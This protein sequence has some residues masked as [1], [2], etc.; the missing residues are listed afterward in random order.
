MCGIVGIINKNGAPAQETLL[1]EMTSAITHRGPTDAGIYI[2]GS[3]GL[4]NRR[5]AIIDL[6]GGKQP[7]SNENNDL[8]I[9]YNGE[10]YNF[11]ELQNELINQGHTFRSN[12]DTEVIIHAFETWGKNC[13]NH[14]RGMFAFAIADL[15]NR[16]LFIARDQMGIKPLFYISTP[17]FFA[18]AS[19]LQALRCIPGIPL[20]ID[21]EA[22]DQ[23]LFLQ[24]I[25]AP[26]TIFQKI[27]KLK[28]AHKLTVSFDG[29][30]SEP[31]EYWQLDFVPDFTKNEN[32]WIEGLE[33]V[34]KNSI[35]AHL[36]SD[37]PFGAFLSGGID[38][39]CVV[40]YMSQILNKPVKTFTIGFE[41]EEFNEIKY[42]EEVSLYC[43]TEQYTEILKPKAL[44]ILPMLVR[45]YGEP[46]GDS[47]AIPTYYVSELAHRHVPMVLSGDGGDELFAGYG[48][49][50]GWVSL[51]TGQNRPFWRKVGRKF[52]E[53]LNPSRYP[54]KSVDLKTWFHIIKY[55]NFSSRKKLWRPEYRQQCN[56]SILEFEIYFRRTEGFEL[57]SKAQYMDLKTYLPYDILTK[58]DVAS[59]MHGLEART[60]LTDIRVAEFA[61]TIPQG[62]NLVENG[63]GQLQG[64]TILKKVLR[65]YYSEEFLNRPKMGFGVPIQSWFS[66]AGGQNHFV[67]DILLAKNS[68]ILSFFEPTE[69]KKLIDKNQIGPTW[70]LVFLDEWLNQFG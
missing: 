59:M 16:E 67:S 70:L 58:V 26:K 43:K 51:L 13:V 14:F 63:F 55:L 4:G 8:W 61:A 39:S 60:P 68:K 6:Q 17:S 2:S 69:V 3:L 27:R 11:K 53:I 47:S 42:A 9:T 15:I 30:F 41:E 1:E 66:L 64:K 52:G 12:S 56:P 29:E 34:I 36:V 5:L 32:D 7:L 62:M 31:E 48:T 49:Y 10:I 18:F 54:P 21:I 35:E 24:Y 37:V 57:C 45:H 50:Q 20:D 65:K 19:E 40:T 28:P 46:F 23:Y 22:L 33:S 25:P 38:S 44:E